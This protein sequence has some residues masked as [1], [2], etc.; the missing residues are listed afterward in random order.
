MVLKDKNTIKKNTKTQPKKTVCETVTFGS[1][2]LTK[3]KY[4]IETQQKGITFL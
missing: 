4:S 2:K 1:T 3:P